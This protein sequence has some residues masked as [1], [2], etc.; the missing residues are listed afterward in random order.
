VRLPEP[1]ASALTFALDLYLQRQSSAS[2][3][4][5][6]YALEYAIVNALEAFTAFVSMTLF[7]NLTLTRASPLHTD[8][9]SQHVISAPKAPRKAQSHTSLLS[10]LVRLVTNPVA[11]L[12][13]A[14]ES[15]W[16]PTEDNAAQRVELD[17][18]A[19]RQVLLQRLK[20]V[21]VHYVILRSKTQKIIGR[22]S[23]RLAHCCRRAR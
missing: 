5:H 4:P 13:T 22:R 15:L 17:H 8:T 7:H 12:E 20:D 9:S 3:S 11:S 18:D 2:I 14:V 16:A 19:R 23:G 6:T 1:T 21:C 10:P